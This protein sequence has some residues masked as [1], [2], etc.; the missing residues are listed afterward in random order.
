MN[1]P[2]PLTQ[3]VIA[4]KRKD[5][6]QMVQQCLDAGEKASDI[7]EHRLVPGMMTVGE[8]FKRN[9]I[10]V[11]EML[12]AARAMNEALKIL[13]PLL[14]AAG[15][16][17]E[18]KALIGTVE[19]DL[20]DI[21]KNLVAMMWKGANIEVIDLGVNVSPARFVAA[22]QQH[23]PG[24]VGLSALLTTT[25]PAM[26]E[27]VK[28]VRDTGLPVKIVIGGAPVTAEFARE[29]GADGYSM[30]AGSAVDTALDLL[31]N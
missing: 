31:R 1:D 3:A 18:H 28:S 27:I 22:I 9:E 15:V 10:F 12:I 11:P 24:L 23:K 14:V 25:M 16:K 6:P 8:R 4:G 19:G 20:H 13:E 5:I 29:I 21:G 26:R 2:H 17:P 7:V 30:D